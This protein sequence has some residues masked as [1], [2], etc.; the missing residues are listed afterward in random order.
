M[1]RCPLRPD[2]LSR[3]VPDTEARS[4]RVQTI[5][6]N[7]P[8]ATVTRL[9]RS[10]AAAAD[11]ATASGMAADVTVAIGDCSDRQPPL[12]DAIHGAAEYIRFGENL[13]HG[14]GQNRLARGASEDVFVFVNPD[15]H[16]APRALIELAGALAD[17]SVGLAEARQLPFEHPKTYDLRTGETEWCSGCCLAVRR[18]VF[19]EVG[20]FDDVHFPLH[21]DDVDLSWRVRGTGCRLLYVPDAVVFHDKRPAGAAPE[22]APAEQYHQVWAKLMLGSLY[23]NADVVRDTSTWVREHGS[24]VQRRALDDFDRFVASNPVSVRSAAPGTARFVRGEYTE[25]RW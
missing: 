25:H 7:T 18:S 13:G 15:V 16:M 6:Y 21:G 20:G 14:G 4:V 8:P 17:P 5:L 10:I 3:L 2:L 9:L 1:I 12:S 23:D 11:V 22:A 24:P 19:E